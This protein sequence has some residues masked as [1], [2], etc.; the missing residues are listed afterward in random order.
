M[1]TSLKASPEFQWGFYFADAIRENHISKAVF[2][3]CWCGLSKH[4]QFEAQN[5]PKMWNKK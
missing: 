5:S 4:F 3:E 2:N 1:L